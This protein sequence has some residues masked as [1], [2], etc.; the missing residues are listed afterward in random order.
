MASTARTELATRSD[1]L[2]DAERRAGTTDRVQAA[3]LASM[4]REL[5][6]PMTSIIGYADLLSGSDGLQLTAH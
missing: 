1:A 2:A 6:D 5:R 3:F 4:S